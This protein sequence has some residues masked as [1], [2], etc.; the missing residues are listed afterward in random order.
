MDYITEEMKTYAIELLKKHGCDEYTY[1]GKWADKVLEDLKAGY[2]PGE[3]KYPYID[4]ANAILEISKPK[5]IVRSKYIVVWSNDSCCDS[6][7]IDFDTIEEAK[8]YAL[9]I[10]TEW[11]VQEQAKW[12]GDKPTPEEIEDFNYM[13]YNCY[14]EVQEY[15][16]D[17]DEYYDTECITYEDEDAIGW[18]E[19]NV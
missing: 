5:P 18:K 11:I 17:K 1:G 8:H 9:D 2:K 3:L 12:K 14:V 13:I 16:P 7:N 10:L 19:I 6:E 15:D 4:V